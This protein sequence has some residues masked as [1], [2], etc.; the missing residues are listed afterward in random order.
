MQTIAV[1]DFGTGNLRSVSKAV[2]HVAPRERIVVTRDANTVR[3]ADRVILPGQGAMGSWFAAMRERGLGDAVREVLGRVPVLGICLGMQAMLDRSDE[4]GGID[5]L[6]AVRGRVK[7]FVRPADANGAFK[8]PHMGWNRVRQAARHP[9]WAG[10]ADGTRFYFV[11]SYFAAPRDDADVA[12]TT[13]YIVDFASAVARANL[14]AVQFQPEKSH[15]QGL[16]LLGN[17][18]RWNGI[19]DQ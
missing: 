8:I 14:F 5:G 16:A 2:E 7:R 3:A 17:F 12:G 1:V 13:D 19:H 4:D 18:V 10:I 6:G 11:H 15:A 9:L